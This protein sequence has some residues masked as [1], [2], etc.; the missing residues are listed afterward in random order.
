MS[1]PGFRS[2]RKESRRSGLKRRVSHTR[3][4]N[5]ERT[6]NPVRAVSD[7]SPEREVTI[8]MRSGESVVNDGSR[9][10]TVR[11][12]LFLTPGRTGGVISRIYQAVT[13]FTN[14][15]CHNTHAKKIKNRKSYSIQRSLSARTYSWALWQGKGG[16]GLFKT[17]CT[18]SAPNTYFA[19]VREVDL[20]CCC[21]C[22]SLPFSNL[23]TNEGIFYHTTYSTRPQQC[24]RGSM[25]RSECMVIVWMYAPYL[26]PYLY[27]HI[28]D[29]RS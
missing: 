29:K 5:M 26:S 13:D 11:R 17:V 27:I 2:W 20:L 10:P 18:S 8:I 9:E 16:T 15:D 6:R 14:N 24:P 25:C 4:R 28:R 1:K 12:Q 21:C 19:S 22:C 3:V 23:N 7:L